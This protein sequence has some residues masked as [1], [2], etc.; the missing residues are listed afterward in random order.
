MWIEEQNYTITEGDSVIITLATNTDNYEFDFTVTLLTLV[1]YYWYWNGYGYG[2]RLATGESCSVTYMVTRFRKTHHY[3]VNACILN[4]ILF[5]T[6]HSTAG[7]DYEAGPY[8]V[9]FTAGQ[10][11][12]TLTVS[13]IDDNT[14]ELT[15]YFKVAINST[16]QPSVVEIAAPNKTVIPI[17]DN[18]PGINFMCTV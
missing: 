9:T 14:T 7:S 5:S 2:Y 15:E 6:F 11:Y 13:T 18:D 4:Y 10:V 1:D 16:D 8:T 12:A 3:F 17:E